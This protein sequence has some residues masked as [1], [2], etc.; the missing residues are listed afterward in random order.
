MLYH[1]LTTTLTK[2]IIMEF[3]ISLPWLSNQPPRKP[4]AQESANPHS[5]TTLFTNQVT[6][7]PNNGGASSDLPK[8]IKREN[9]HLVRSMEEEEEE[10]APATPR[11]CYYLEQRGTKRRRDVFKSAERNDSQEPG[12]R[13]ATFQELCDFLVKYEI[14]YQEFPLLQDV[15]DGYLDVFTEQA[16]FIFS[17]SSR[18]NYITL[19]IKHIGYLGFDKRTQN[20]KIVKEGKDVKIQVEKGDGKEF[21]G[22]CDFT[23]YIEHEK[24]SKIINLEQCRYVDVLQ[25]KIHN[26]IDKVERRSFPAKMKRNEVIGLLQP[27][28]EGTYLLYYSEDSDD[29]RSFEIAYVSNRI[30]DED[31][32]KVEFKRFKITDLGQI[33]GLDDNGYYNALEDNAMVA[34][35]IEDYLPGVSTMEQF[36]KSDET[37]NYHSTGKSKCAR[38]ITY[39]GLLDRYY[40]SGLIHCDYLTMLDVCD[41]LPDL[42]R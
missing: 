25:R 10:E 26:L 11:E 14:S 3:H 13:K 4:E 37:Y 35:W 31:V 27:C 23:R 29:K 33:E 39:K 34:Q 16:G 36:L 18:E 8:R 7:P 6:F 15:L 41:P 30:V 28:E 12:C 5:Y 40:S 22:L 1:H 32:R 42:I 9:D 19:H 20:Y 24:G 21:F 2:V 38:R 17:Q